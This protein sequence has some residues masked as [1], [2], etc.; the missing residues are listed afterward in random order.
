MGDCGSDPDHQGDGVHL[1]ALAQG[2]G[3][4]KT[5]QVKRL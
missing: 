3:G 1:L 4:L 2:V 5:D